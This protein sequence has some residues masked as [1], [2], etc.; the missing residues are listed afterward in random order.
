MREKPNAESDNEKLGLQGRAQ[1]HL[2]DTAA[3]VLLFLK[4]KLFKE[5]MFFVV[6]LYLPLVIIQVQTGLEYSAG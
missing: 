6:I 3:V 2:L 4:A 5:A 1:K